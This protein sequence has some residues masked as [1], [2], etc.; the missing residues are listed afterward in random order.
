M[1]IKIPGTSEIPLVNTAN[2]HNRKEIRSE[3]LHRIHQEKLADFNRVK[4]QDF[5]IHRTSLRDWELKKDISE[6][7]RYM[8]LKRTVEYGLYQYSKY[9]GNNIDV[10][11]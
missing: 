6:I 3:E 1:S 11:V 2:L 8:S 4:R 9:L 5:D 10:T 7:D